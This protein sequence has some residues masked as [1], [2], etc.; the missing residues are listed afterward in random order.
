MKPYLDAFR[1]LTI[2]DIDRRQAGDRLNAIKAVSSVQLSLDRDA[3][4][5]KGLDA[6]LHALCDAVLDAH[7]RNARTLV[8]VNRVD[9]AQR[10][11]RLLR[12]RRPDR[13]NVLIHARFRAAERAEQAR[14]LREEVDTDRIV[15]ATQAIEAGVDMSSKVLVTELAPWSSLVQRFGRCNRYGEH[16]ASGGA[17]ILWVN[18]EDDADALPYR[19]EELVGA[20]K[21][22]NALTSASPETLPPTDEHR[23]LTAV[24][25][26]K[27]LLD[28]F[29]TDPD[30]S[31]FDVDVS[32]YIRDSGVPGLQVFWRDFEDPNKPH[33]QGAPDRRELC[34]ISI[35]QA[36][37]LHKR[38]AW[39]WDGLDEEWVKL[40]RDPRPGMTLLLR[41]ADSGYDAEIGFDTSLKKPPVMVI[42]PKT[43]VAED[44]YSEDW[45]S[46]Q[47]RPVMLA[48]HLGDVAKHARQ[49]CNAVGETAHVEQVVRAG[50][51]HDVGKA[52]E[53]FDA[54]MHSC[55]K[56][57]I[58]F[59][60]KSPC[61]GRHSRR[62]FR[63]ELA[64]MLAWLAQH[65]DEPHA[66]IVAYLIAAHHGKVRMSLRAMPTEQGSDGVIR[67]AR[68]VWEA[69]AKSFQLRR[70]RYAR[71]HQL[72][73]VEYP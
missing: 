51:W 70:C 55:D 32:D 45:R 25:R 61:R 49:L 65:G 27:D 64:S 48:D 43:V 46:R 36:K 7:D 47:P 14:R 72:H 13:H 9:R 28:L 24:L 15:V 42:T 66:D 63:H 12:E 40:V 5:K 41:A 20:R 10:L 58:G 17:H 54:T 71:A 18:I 52:H 6:Y 34:P 62:F 38:G 16:N 11:Y 44:A 21:K 35:G 22:L 39:R 26:R 37:D 60:A 56:A 30:L 68:G 8:I 59:L 31:G 2:G 3:G 33:Q 69:A 19:I 57:P 53:I 50:R 4:S 73:L 29:N 23:A 67:F 1:L